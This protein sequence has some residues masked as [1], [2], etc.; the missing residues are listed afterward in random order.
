L[1]DT[2]AEIS[3]KERLRNRY[4][5]VIEGEAEPDEEIITKFR[6]AGVELKRL[7]DR[8]DS[9]ER[10]INATAAPKLTKIPMIEYGDPKE[11]NLKLKDEIRKRVA[12]IKLIFKSV[13]FIDPNLSNASLPP[14]MN[15]SA[16]RSGKG[17]IF[18]T[19]TFVNGATKFAVIDGLKA[20]LLW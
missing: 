20:T 17:Q 19:V 14:S 5:R 3:Q 10:E 15:L 6:A 12:Q 18:I 16:L 11:N 2:L 8:K 13:A 7:K 9:L 4:L 1:D